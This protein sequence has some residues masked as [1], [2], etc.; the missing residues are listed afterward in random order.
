[1]GSC[2][3]RK[4]SSV[5][6]TFFSCNPPMLY[7]NMTPEEDSSRSRNIEI[8][9]F[10]CLLLK[11]LPWT[12]TTHSN[13]GHA[14]YFVEAPCFLVPQRWSSSAYRL[15]RKHLSASRSMLDDASHFALSP[16]PPCYTV[17]WQ[18]VTIQDFWKLCT[19]TSNTNSRYLAL[20]PPLPSRM[21][22]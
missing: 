2:N 3:S 10:G 19:C 18:F 7:S 20:F 1:M 22:V 5:S 13:N 9:P 11:C 16:H 15:R 4:F 12:W 14:N 8:K 6:C 17:T 21:W